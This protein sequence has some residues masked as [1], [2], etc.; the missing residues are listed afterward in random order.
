MVMSM[1]NHSS[2]NNTMSTRL[3]LYHNS[4]DSPTSWKEEKDMYQPIMKAMQSS[5]LYSSKE[6]IKVF[7]THALKDFLADTT[8]VEYKGKRL[9]YSLLYIAKFKLEVQGDKL[10]MASHWPS[11]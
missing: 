2:Q 4:K 7:D 10:D 3:I 8:V 9:L 11:Y 5:S 6:D 1:S